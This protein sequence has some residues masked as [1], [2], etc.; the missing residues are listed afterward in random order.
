MSYLSRAD[1][2]TFIIEQRSPEILQQ[3]TQQSVALSTFRQIPVSSS[4]LRVS[5]TD[6]FPQAQWLM[7]GVA[8]DADVDIDRIAKPWL[9]NALGGARDVLGTAP[10]TRSTVTPLRPLRPTI[11][12]IKRIRMLTRSANR[13]LLVRLAQDRAAR[14][15]KFAAHGRLPGQR[16]RFQPR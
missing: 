11:S 3:A 16:T 15:M 12:P 9:Q 2:L 7:P 6:A 8:P 14:R 4:T 5:M 10:P 1:A 13:S